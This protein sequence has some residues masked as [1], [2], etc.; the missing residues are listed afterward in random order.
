MS[1]AIPQ[2]LQISVIECHEFVF[3]IQFDSISDKLFCI[4]HIGQLIPLSL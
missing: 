3:G 4:V 2:R 1:E